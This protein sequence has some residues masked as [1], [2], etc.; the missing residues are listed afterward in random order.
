MKSFDVFGSEPDTACDV[1][2]TGDPSRMCGGEAHLSLYRQAGP[3]GVLLG[4]GEYT[5][6]VHSSPGYVHELHTT[7]AYTVHMQ[8]APY[9][10]PAAAATV[11]AQPA[12]LCLV[13][14]YTSYDLLR[15]RLPPRALS[16]VRLPPGLVLTL[17]QHDGFGG[18]SLNLT[19][20]Q[21]CLTSAA[22][23]MPAATRTWA[24]PPRACDGGTWDDAAAS[25]RLSYLGLPPAYVPRPNQETAARAFEL[26]TQGRLTRLYDLVGDTAAR[27]AA[28]PADAPVDALL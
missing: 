11:C 14:E 19:E 7:C 12:T 16:S 8:H 23:T 6:Y 15:L 17:H 24:V 1:P 3:R 13:G 2:C 20:D 5:S 22:C 9:A 10:Q 25:V 21:P 27:A 26:S 28:R 4:P 18:L